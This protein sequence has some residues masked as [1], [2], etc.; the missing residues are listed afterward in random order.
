MRIALYVRVST[1][2]QAE[3]GMSMEDQI[4]ACKRWAKEKGHTVVE[5]FQERGASAFALE[6]RRPEFDRMIAAA[7]S[8]A[9]PF[10]LIA[11]HMQSRFYR[12]NADRELLERQLESKGVH[13][14]TLGQPRPE[15][16]TSS[17]IL[18]NVTGIVDEAQSIASG[19]RVAEC[20]AASA[21][22]GYFNGARPPY[23]YK[24]QATDIP[25]RS[26]VKKILVI[27]EEEAVIVRRIFALARFGKSAMVMGMKR[28]AE[29]LNANGILRRGTQW[30][31][32]YVEAVLKNSVYYGKLI[33]FRRN[34]RTG[35]INP[36]SKWITTKVPP[37]LP[38][39]VFDEVQGNL[40]KRRPPN[41]E[42][43]ASQVPTL[44][45]GLLICNHCKKGLMLMTGKSGKYKYYRCLSKQKISPDACTCPNFPKAELEKVVLTAVVDRVLTPQ[46]VSHLMGELGELWKDAKKPDAGHLRTL[47]TRVSA[48]DSSLARIYEELDKEHLDLDSSLQNFIRAKQQAR[49][50][51]IEELRVLDARLHL[52]FRKFGCDQIESFV[53]AAKTT[54]SDPANPIA[55]Q[56]LRAVVTEIRVD[57]KKCRIRGNR[58]QLASAISRWKGNEEEVPSDVSD[59]RARLGSNQQPLPSEGSTLSIEL[60]AHR[61]VL[62]PVLRVQRLRRANAAAGK[63][64]RIPL[65]PGAVHAGPPR[66]PGNVSQPPLFGT[67]RGSL[68]L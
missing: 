11:V 15:D 57:A 65:L 59:W 60:R 53:G 43:R 29:E 37:I 30:N 24:T 35:A 31:I 4:A 18:R 41:T 13:L 67:G 25:A 32:R 64:H 58:A 14:V 23:G 2:R 5:I 22:A 68:A 48:L 61:T 20:M 52:P 9:K 39:A 51:V 7:L 33:T 1:D 36:P 26:G 6:K 66:A 63:S 56:F 54:L 44:L 34:S 12:R 45:T 49:A 55:R 42:N 16:E 3:Q 47:R 19:K 40:A 10:D 8:D 50:T 46:R 27:N 21:K 17:F 62:Q 38:K 28:I